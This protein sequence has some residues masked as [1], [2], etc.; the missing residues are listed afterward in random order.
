MNIGQEVKG[1]LDMK[2]NDDKSYDVN[3]MSEIGGLV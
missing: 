2:V 3:L 1:V